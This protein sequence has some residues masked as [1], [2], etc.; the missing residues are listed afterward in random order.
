MCCL[1]TINAHLDALE[2]AKTKRELTAEEVSMRADMKTNLAV[3]ERYIQKEL[4]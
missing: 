2:A 1:S 3:L 4:E